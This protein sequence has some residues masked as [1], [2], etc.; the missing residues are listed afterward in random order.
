MTTG[1]FLW[2]TRM[3]SRTPP[4]AI[5]FNDLFFRGENHRTTKIQGSVWSEH[6][7]CGV[8]PQ[9]SCVCIDSWNL[10]GKSFQAVS[11]WGWTPLKWDE[12]AT[13]YINTCVYCIIY[14]YIYIYIYCILYIC[15]CM[16]RLCHRDWK[17]INQQGQ[18][19][20]MLDPLGCHTFR[21]F[22]IQTDTR[23]MSHWGMANGWTSPKWIN[24]WRFVGTHNWTLDDF[25]MTR[26][27]YQ[28]T[29]HSGWGKSIDGATFGTWQNMQNHRFRPGEILGCSRF[30]KSSTTVWIVA[31]ATSKK[32]IGSET[33]LWE[34]LIILVRW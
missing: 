16:Y 25:F 34:P 6:S 28:K 17:A 7:V 18:H 11:K 15:I 29:D 9:T 27:D 12:A 33:N 32:Q 1:W 4:S 23:I 13:V 26:L 3:T 5:C 14:I 21:P 19:D 22:R 31:P 10:G 24:G 20:S 8:S 30:S 2:G